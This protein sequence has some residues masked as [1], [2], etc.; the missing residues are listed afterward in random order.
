MSEMLGNRYFI[1]R[2]FDKA[3]TYL[4]QALSE[5]PGSVDIIKKLIICY[6]ETGDVEKAFNHFYRLGTERS[7]H[8]REY[9]FILRRLSLYRINPQMETKGKIQPGQRKPLSWPG[10]ALFILQ[11]GEVD[12][13]LRKS[14]EN[15]ST[16]EQNF[17]HP[18]KVKIPAP[19]QP[20]IVSERTPFKI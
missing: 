7:A 5:S 11:S 6:I 20:Q 2:Q 13:I 9:G 19:G 15:H 8:H 12:R 1:A 4:E 10:H 17:I 3:V 16:A 18:E 14:K